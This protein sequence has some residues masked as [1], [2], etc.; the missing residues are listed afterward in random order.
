VF[1]LIGVIFSQSPPE[2]MFKKSFDILNNMYIDSIDQVKVVE[3][4]IEGMLEDLDPYTKLLI[5]ENKDSHDKLSKGKYGGI[6]IRIGSSINS[7]VYGSKSSSIPS[8]A[9]STTLT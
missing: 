2:D 9:D 1:I 8:I 3:S 7:F 5:D 6:G 4:A